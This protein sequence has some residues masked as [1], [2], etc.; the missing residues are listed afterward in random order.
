MDKEKVID[1]KERYPQEI[2]E[3][4]YILQKLKDGR[5]YERSHVQSDGYLTT[6]INKL[7]EYLN[8]LFYKIEYNEPS[9]MERIFK[10]MDN[11]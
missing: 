10:Q 4:Q 5:Y 9:D 8:K 3:I 6:N 2:N 11:L 7:E 1:I